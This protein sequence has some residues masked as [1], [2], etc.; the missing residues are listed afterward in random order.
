MPFR[1]KLLV[2]ALSLWCGT[3][4]LLLPPSRGQSKKKDNSDLEL[5]ERLMIARR[6]YQ[7]VLE[8]LRIHYI[9][10]GDIERAKWAEE[11]LIAF[12]RIPK[13]AFRLELDVP[14]PT[15]RGTTNIP[16]ANKLYMRALAYKGKGWGNDYIDN[17]RRAELLLQQLLTK[18][19]QSNRISDAAYQLGDIYE[20]APYKQYRRAAMYF[21]RCYQWN[22]TTGF[23]ARMRAARIYDRNLLDRVKATEIYKEVTNHETDPN[24]YKEAVRRMRELSQQR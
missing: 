13:R 11:E 20:N 14:P 5:V 9:K 18:Y 3:Y 6:D 8:I 19:P 17:Q 1:L 22:P 2:L 16:A 12:H 23:D 7:R 10:A 24:V 4:L 15:L 21:E